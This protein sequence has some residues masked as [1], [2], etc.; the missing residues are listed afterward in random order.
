VKRGN[1]FV[2]VEIREAVS[3]LPLLATSTMDIW[4][5][6][7]QPEEGPYKKDCHFRLPFLLLEETSWE[8]HSRPFSTPSPVTALL[9]LKIVTGGEIT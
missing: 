6:L 3:K 7:V 5:K 1:G 4:L 8:S 9:G 2:Q